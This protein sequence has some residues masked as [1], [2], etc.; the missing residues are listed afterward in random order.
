[1]PTYQ[2][3][4]FDLDG[5]LIDSVDLIV[6]SYL[7]TFAEHGLPALTR[8]EILAGMGRPLRAIFGAWTED[9]ATMDRWI[10]TYREYNL[11]NH[12]ARVTAYPGV[13]EMVRRIRDAGHRTALVTSKNR[14][15][16]DRGLTLVGLRDAIELIVGADDVTHPKPH[17]EPVEQALARLGVTTAG[18]LF[19][20]DSHHDV[21]SGRAAGVGTVGVT[22]GPFDRAHLEA[23]AP[24]FYC[25]T[26]AELLTLL[27]M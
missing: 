26:P 1:M 23:S 2:T 5:T 4:L 10:A 13:V 14:Y 6:D 3:V 7:H 19:V 17:A 21:Y 9:P 12:D 8:E 27:G 25:D 15:G 20:G 18:C 11:A 16:A 24:D 22:W